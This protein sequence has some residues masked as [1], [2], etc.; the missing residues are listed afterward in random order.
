MD[1]EIIHFRDSDKILEEKAMISDVMMT[2][3]YLY[4]ELVGAKYRK[5]ILRDALEVMDWRDKGADLRV[6]VQRTK[7]R[8][9][10]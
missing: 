10:N 5:E 1:F 9:R 8:G 4:D 2:C 6:F 3:A 7:G